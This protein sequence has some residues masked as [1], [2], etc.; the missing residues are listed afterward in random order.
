MTP[1]NVVQIEREIERLL[2]DYPELA[3]DETLRADMIDGETD[4]KA[5]LSR[6]VDRCTK[7]R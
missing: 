3:E 1:L 2:I 5:V 7:R 6:I 4:A